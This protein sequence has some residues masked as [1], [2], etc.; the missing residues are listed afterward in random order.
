MPMLQPTHFGR[1]TLWIVGAVLLS[2][3]AAPLGPIAGGK[4]EGE[5][6][7]WPANWDHAED[8][9]NVLLETDPA[10]PYSVTIWGVGVRDEFFV[11]ASTR[12]NQWARKIEN[13]PRV[14]LAVDGTLY[15]AHAEILTDAA[16]AETVANKFFD[17]YD[18]DPD[19]LEGGGAFYRLTRRIQ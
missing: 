19:N 15:Q 17:K 2:S 4:L 9:E 18:M 16:T 13:D 11:G 3:C 8:C 6:S 1:T 5:V 12:S 10:D 7:P 14:V